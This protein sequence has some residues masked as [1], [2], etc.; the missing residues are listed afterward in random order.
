MSYL[1]KVED[2][3]KPAKP[4]E[5]KTRKE[6]WEGSLPKTYDEW[7]QREGMPYNMAQ[8]FQ[9]YMSARWGNRELNTSYGEEWLNRFKKHTAWLSSDGKGRSILKDIGYTDEVTA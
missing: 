3:F 5:L 7:G 2:I 1:R 6:T 4:K 9:K 8:A